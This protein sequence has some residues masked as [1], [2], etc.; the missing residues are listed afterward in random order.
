[1][2]KHPQQTPP[3]FQPVPALAFV[4]ESHQPE[5]RVRLESGG[6]GSGATLREAI[7]AAM[8]EKG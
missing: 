1:M 3:R 5:Y 2:T 7:D 6:K 8:Q 4:I